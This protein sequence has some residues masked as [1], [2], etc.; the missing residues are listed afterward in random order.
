MRNRFLLAS[1][2]TLNA[3]FET[4]FIQNQMLDGLPYV[5]DNEIATISHGTVIYLELGEINPSV[6]ATLKTNG[7]RVVLFQMGDE[8]GRK[9]IS[10][11]SQCDAVFRNYYFPAI[12]DDHPL[13]SRM[14]WVPNGFRT[15]IGPRSRHKLKRVTERRFLSSFMGWLSN[16]Q[17][18]N[19]ERAKFSSVAES[20]APNLFL[21]STTGFGQ[22]FNV[23]LYSTILESSVFTPCPAGN[24]A[25]TIRLYDALEC[26]S[27]P[28]SLDHG[29]LRARK[30]LFDP[31]FPIL[32]SWDELPAFLLAQHGRLVS[33]PGELQSLQTATVEWWE[34]HKRRI[35]ETLDLQLWSLEGD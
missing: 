25:E 16:A 30:A 12:I 9:D 14:H 31:P 4:W 15:G 5:L 22:G 8:L 33:R 26:G 23:G 13:N 19:D 3:A 11:Y 1:P 28:I 18:H 6:I 17:S 35:A 24:S 34:S 10:L 20:C 32:A 27:I 21:S 2:A 7:N 29:F